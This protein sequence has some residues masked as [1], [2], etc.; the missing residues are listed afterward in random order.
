MLTLLL[1]FL[2]TDILKEEVLPVPVRKR[3]QNHFSN[4]NQERK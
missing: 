4:Y 2:K 3:L 1:T